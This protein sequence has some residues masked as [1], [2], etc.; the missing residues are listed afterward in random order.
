MDLHNKN[1]KIYN[2]TK[3]IYTGKK[4]IDSINLDAKKKKDNIKQLKKHIAELSHVNKENI[5]EIRKLNESIGKQNNTD[6]DKNKQISNSNNKDIEV[7]QT[8]ETNNDEFKCEMC[9]NSFINIQ[10]HK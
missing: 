6:K 7:I 8:K 3:K 2:L 1:E 9:M 5:T 4:Y 10:A